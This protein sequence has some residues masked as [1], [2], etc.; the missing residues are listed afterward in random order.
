MT[1]RI[2]PVFVSHGAPT[3]VLEDHPARDFLSRLGRELP[4]PKAILCVSAHWDTDEPAVS[5]AD[6]V[7]RWRGR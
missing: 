7:G 3:L 6:P 5:T 4:R 1:Q 2:P